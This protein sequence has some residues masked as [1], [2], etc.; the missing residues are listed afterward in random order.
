MHY[1]LISAGPFRLLITRPDTNAYGNAA[2]NM[3]TSFH[4]SRHLA[5]PLYVAPVNPG[6]HQALW[7][8]ECAGVTRVPTSP[9]RTAALLTGSRVAG[10]LTR[11]GARNP[12]AVG[13]LPELGAPAPG[14]SL[15]QAYFGLDLRRTCAEVPLEIRLPD[16]AALAARAAAARLGLD[17]RSR[18]VTLHV[19]EAGYKASLGLVDREKDTAR[20][21]R[22]ESYLEAVDWLVARGYTVV[23]FGDAQMTPIL[24]RGL[25]DL[26]TS[27]A[28]TAELEIWCVLRSRFFI[29]SD[30]G[31]YNLGVLTGVPC[32][33][34]NITHHVGAYP[35]RPHD[36][37]IL[38]HVVDTGTGATLRLDDMLTPAHMKARWVPGRY[39]FR[40]NT[41]AEIRDA[42]EEM[43]SALDAGTRRPVSDAQRAFRAR[44]TGFLD[45]DYGGRKQKR[46]SQ[47][48]FYLGDGWACDRFAAGCL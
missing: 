11:L 19:R 27:P 39:A 26:A 42:V 23:R 13:T 8:L 20:N 47:P 43:E 5:V 45:S 4:L 37:Y 18:I 7:R 46:A 16:A 14:D 44:L 48:G 41:A 12:G 32:L 30:C 34:V 38:K 6:R 21:A 3:A 31:P 2:L 9:V 36:R 33:G 1:A 29:A 10:A 22:P 15:A 24:R 40:D 17:D 25:V 35:L 28:R